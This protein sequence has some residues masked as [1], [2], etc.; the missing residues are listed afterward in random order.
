V[1]IVEE[2]VSPVQRTALTI[3]ERATKY[4][5]ACDPAISGAGGHNTT[6]RV[7]CTLLH[8]FCLSPCAAF[9]L[10][11]IYNEKCQPPWRDGELRHKILSAAGAGSSKGRGH[12]LDADANIPAPGSAA[13]LVSSSPSPK[14]PTP[15]LDA[16]D[17]IARNGPGTFDVWENSP[18]RFESDAQKEV[19]HTE[20]IV[21]VGFPA[22]PFL[23]AGWSAWR[24]ET[25]RR[26]AWRGLLSEM[27]LLVPN[28]MIA[29]S[30]ITKEGKQSQHTLAATARRVYQVLDFDFAPTDRNGQPTIFVPLLEG[31]KAD[32]IS[33]LDACAALSVHLA[34]QLPSWLLFLSSGAKSGHSWFNV[35]GLPSARSVPFSP[36]PFASAR[37]LNSGLVRSSPGCLMAVA[38]T[39]TARRFSTSILKTLSI[40]ESPQP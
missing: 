29:P 35:H 19:S 27:P 36:K 2:T 1:A 21:D 8:G 11:K 6:F 23:C 40:H 5:A 18:L 32:K 33:T 20:Q 3:E 38:R 9:R 26:S 4:L 30:G 34:R 28:P 25:R 13:I 22:D 24:F 12:L 16:I 31:W 17:R 37:I 14:W 39:V 15:D 10:L 7:A